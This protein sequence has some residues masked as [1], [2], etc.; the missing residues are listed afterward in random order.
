MLPS[1]MVIY[2]R[3]SEHVVISRSPN[4]IKKFQY[5]LLSQFNPYVNPYRSL[6]FFRD[7]YATRSSTDSV[8]SEVGWVGRA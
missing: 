1:R 6:D 8:E 3:S 4:P 5:V 2:R 7:L